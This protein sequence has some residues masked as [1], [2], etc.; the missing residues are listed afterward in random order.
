MKKS[1]K[2]A[3]M[4]LMLICTAALA[5]SCGSEASPYD[6]NDAEG[7]TVSVK[8]DANGG[9]FTTN[10]SVIVDSYCAD[11]LPKN[12]QGKAQIALLSPDNA[13]RGNDAFTA[14]NNGYFLAGWYERGEDGSYKNRWDFDSDRVF[15]DTD[16][17]HSSSEPVLTLYA[18]W[19]PLFKVDFLAR[20]TGELIESYAFDPTD[21]GAMQIELPR[22]NTESGTLDMFK[23]PAIKGS[24]F[25]AAYYD[26]AGEDLAEG[27]SIT[28]SGTINYENGTAQGGTM[29]L[30]LDYTEGEWFHIYTAEQLCDNAS[31]AGNYVIHAD[32]DFSDE[33]WPS[34]FMYGNFV[35]SIT[36]NGHKMSNI[37][38]TQ[39]DNSRLNAGLFGNLTEK[40]K[41]CDVSFEN[42]SFTIKAGARN[43]GASFGLLAGSVSAS[44][45]VSGIK[46]LSSQIFIDS[47]VYFATTDYSIGLVCGMGGVDG[48]DLS[49]ISCSAAGDAPER[50]EIT[51]DGGSV[52]VVIKNT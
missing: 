32:L 38:I 1:I 52:S 18:V 2:K 17:S 19:I 50:V 5:V 34:S 37:K 48:I 13:L 9:I 39:T 29:S 41:L 36:G 16:A 35:G 31:V 21:E 22:W 28:H 10:T 6:T 23:F 27:E 4:V 51:L 20:S 14:V 8:Y 26:A 44:A 12:A 15:V 46:I 42:V 11:Q 47:G 25:A 49:E 43:A 33:I 24:T 3:L 30:Y 40:S 45:E 7:Y